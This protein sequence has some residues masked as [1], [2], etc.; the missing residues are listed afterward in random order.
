MKK[1][2]R[3]LRREKAPRPFR[4]FLVVCVC[5]ATAGALTAAI[6]AL[7]SGNGEPGA[8][9]QL[10]GEE[11]PEMP[12]DPRIPETV[13]SGLLLRE[14]GIATAEGVGR[15]PE[16]TAQGRLLGRRAALTDARRNLLVLRQKLLDGKFDVRSV[17]GKIAE[18]RIYSEKTDGALY[19]LKVDVPLYRLMKGDVPVE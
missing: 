9:A 15:I 13:N 2:V 14:Q 18:V 16:D 10:V 6:P 8:E 5:I 3:R 17:S 7:F 1:Q 4:F 11:N 19:Y 12:R